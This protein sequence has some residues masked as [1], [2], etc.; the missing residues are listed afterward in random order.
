MSVEFR[1]VRPRL[2]AGVDLAAYRIVQEALTNAI[3]HAGAATATVNVEFDPAAVVVSVGDDGRGS[4]GGESEGGPARYGLLGMRER[5]ALYGGELRAGAR[6][7]GGFEVVARIPVGE[8][9]MSI[10]ALRSDILLAVAVTMACEAELFADG[11]SG[12]R[13][14][15]AAALLAAGGAAVVWRRRAPIVASCLTLVLT[16][17]AVALAPGNDLVTPQYV[18]HLAPYTIGAWT[19]RRPAPAGLAVCLVAIGVFG[20]VTAASAGSWVFGVGTV[21]GSFF[22]GRAVR[23]QRLLVA[24]LEVV[25]ASIAASREEASRLVV[26]ESGLASPRT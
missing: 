24:E 18:L 22:V 17:A 1:G 12:P 5:V 13:R 8:G 25:A 7:G 11:H 6:P 26:E 3:K 23:S 2:P 21:A 10:E 20:V 4:A 9:G 19:N 15:A 14:V 16:L